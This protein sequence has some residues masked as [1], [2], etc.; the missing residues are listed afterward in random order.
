MTSVAYRYAAVPAASA[1]VSRMDDDAIASF[2]AITNAD[3]G[4]AERYLSFAGGDVDQAVLFF[5]ESGGQVPAAQSATN[6]PPA[7]RGDGADE[8]IDIPDEED[9][10]AMA[11]RLASEWG[12]GAGGGGGDA[13][14]R[15]PIARTSGVLQDEMPFDPS[16]LPGMMG[17]RFNP[18]AGNAR[19]V[20][21]PRGVFNQAA[22]SVWDEQ[23]DDQTLLESTGGASA[24][25]AKSS[26]LARLFQP[27]FDLMTDLDLDA[28]RSEARATDRWLMVNLHDSS[29]FQCQILNRDLWKDATVKQV[30]REH[31]IFMQP[32]KDSDEGAQYLQF[33]PVHTYPHISILDPRTGERCRQWSQP[34]GP[35]DFI[36]DVTEFLERYSL[37]EGASNPVAKR[38]K[39]PVKAFADMSEEEQINAAILASA[40]IPQ[41]GDGEESEASDDDDIE[42]V[43]EVDD[44]FSRIPSD[45]FDEPVQS[46]EVTRIQLRFPA[47]RKVRRFGLQDPVERVFAYAKST[48]EA[49]GKRFKIVF[50]RTNL[51]DKLDDTILAAGLKNASLQVE[52]EED[53]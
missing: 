2:C 18:L 20:R 19:G 39:T 6:A 13:E 51:I 12:N 26:R 31:F 53:D 9:D 50:N 46:A 3:H 30:V 17:N 47:G 41:R 25:S 10:E 27:P 45:P 29:D 7:S 35:M 4:T 8:V 38:P 32:A 40:G 48:D 37:D 44:A 36:S 14:V 52:F 49:A 1:D 33:Y 23:S 24:E 22:P 21:R 28:A 5:F 43:T 11:R 34:V 15:A 16:M 42:E